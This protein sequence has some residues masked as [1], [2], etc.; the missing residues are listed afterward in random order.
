[1][2]K[3]NKPF[4]KCKPEEVVFDIIDHGGMYYTS[5]QVWY[6]ECIKEGSNADFILSLQHG[7]LCGDPEDLLIE[8]CKKV[9]KGDLYRLFCKDNNENLDGLKHSGLHGLAKYI[10]NLFPDNIHKELVDMLNRK[11]NQATQNS[12]NNF[13]NGYESEDESEDNELLDEISY[14][15]KVTEGGDFPEEDGP[16]SPA[17]YNTDAE[18]FDDIGIMGIVGGNGNGQDPLI[19][20]A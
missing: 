18:D 3:D 7:I 4:E 19:V 14:Y 11:V 1:M 12:Y 6:Y 10:T 15:K 13:D 5:D 16:Y 9:K 2:K 17:A 20:E 8:I